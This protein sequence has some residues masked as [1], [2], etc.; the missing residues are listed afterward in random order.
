MNKG[1]VIVV[2]AES[3]RSF[4]VLHEDLIPLEEKF[5]Q[6][7]QKIAEKQPKPSKVKPNQRYLAKVEGSWRRVLVQSLL[8]DNKCE[9]LFVDFGSTGTV[10]KA[11]LKKC[12]TFLEHQ[13][14]KVTK[15]SLQLPSEVT[16]HLKADEVFKLMVS[17][18]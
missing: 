4:Y 13:R 12:D 9:V 10:Q 7:I 18:R 14:E 8:E 17:K 3:T 5:Q 15:C 1:N 2:S 11:Y 16:E 6:S